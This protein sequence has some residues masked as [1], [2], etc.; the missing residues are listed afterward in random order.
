MLDELANSLE[1]AG[2]RADPGHEKPAG[3]RFAPARSPEIVPA[4]GLLV[5]TFERD[6]HGSLA[7]I[8]PQLVLGRC[9]GLDA[10][11][12]PFGRSPSGLVSHDASCRALSTKPTS[13]SYCSVEIYCSVETG[14]AD[15]SSGTIPRWKANRTRSVRLRSPSLRM[16][17]ARWLSAVRG[18]MNRPAANAPLVG[19]PAKRGRTSRPPGVEGS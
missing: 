15:I 10:G 1:T 17:L 18:L 4:V 3:L 11:I 9:F 8:V 7:E 14:P 6:I 5:P 19:P 13:S 16:R 12:A 2:R